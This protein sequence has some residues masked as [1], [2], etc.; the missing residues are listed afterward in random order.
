VSDTE[1]W[2][3]IARNDP[4][5]AYQLVYADLKRMARKQLSQ[6]SAFTDLPVTVLVHESYAR[7]AR[8]K[9]PEDRVAFFAY[10]AHAMRSII[11]DYVRSRR[12][13]KRDGVEIS[14]TLAGDIAAVTLNHDQIIAVD[15]ALGELKEIDQRAHD[16]VELRYFAGFTLAECA[17]QLGISIA[18][19]MR[20]WQKA[21]GFLAAMLAEKS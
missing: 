2:A 10:A 14:L 12:T 1:N 18:T 20:D 9:M 21:R 19:A 11:V 5:S 6:Q 16:L 3:A 13:L 7:L 4:A 8:V 17:E 15:E